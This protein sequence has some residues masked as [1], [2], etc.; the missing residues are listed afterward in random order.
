MNPFKIV[1]AVRMQQ[2]VAQQLVTNGPVEGLP[3]YQRLAVKL[4]SYSYLCSAAKS[5]NGVMTR[6]YITVSMTE[7]EYISDASTRCI[8]AVRRAGYTVFVDLVEHRQHDAGA[9]AE[10][11]LCWDEKVICGDSANGGVLPTTTSGRCSGSCCPYC[12][13]GWRDSVE[14]GQ[15]PA[16]VNTNLSAVRVVGVKKGEK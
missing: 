15:T 5:I 1:P 4:L 14:S 12:A 16:V 8:A 3:L 2:V 7:E 6:S 11:T 10:L 9:F 13:K